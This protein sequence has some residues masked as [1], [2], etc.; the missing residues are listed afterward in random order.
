MP[1]P[2]GSDLYVSRPLSNISVAYIQESTDFAA[3][4]VFPP[5][6]VDH[7][8]GSYYIYNK[9]DWFRTQAQKRAPRTESA[10]TGWNISTSTYAADV[11]AVHTDISDQDRANQD[12]PILD[13]DRDATTFVTHDIMLRR[14]KDWVTAFFGTGKWTL[15]DQ[16]G[17][18][19]VAANQFI[20]WDRASSTPLEDIEKQRLLIAKTTGLK[21]NVLVIGQEVYSVFKNHAEF[22]ERI[23]Y[24]EKGVVTLDLIAGL[25]DLEKIVVPMVLENTAEE[26]ATDAFSFVHGKAALLAYAAPRPSRMTP[27]AGYSF[28]W[29]GYLGAATRG[30]RIKKFRMEPLASDRVEVESAYSFKVVSADLAVYFTAAVQ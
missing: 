19:T 3:S 12:S 26:G 13:L 9:G 1:Q 18:A 10:G 20:S 30:T 16:T 23:K 21:P 28:E 24:S 27:S 14:E 11:N 17:A 22:I 25:M 5:V 7:Q 15:T 29:T 6:P 2:T 4:T 8:Y